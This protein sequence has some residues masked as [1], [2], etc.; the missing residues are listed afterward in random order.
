M[1]LRDIVVGMDGREF[2]LRDGY[3]VHEL[4]ELNAVIL[5]PF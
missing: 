2:P 5:E 3:I 4:E 1:W